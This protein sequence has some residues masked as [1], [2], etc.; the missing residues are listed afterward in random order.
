MSP[1]ADLPRRRSPRMKDYDYSQ[2]GTYFV[3][4][5][6]QRRRNL[7]GKVVDG[8]MH[9]NDAGVIAQKTWESLPERFPVL[10]DAWVIMPNHVHGILIITDSTP[11]YPL[12]GNSLLGEM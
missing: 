2:P 7:F 12:H 10:L 9:L 11:P 3:T 1:N 6:T 5:C 8:T 4:I